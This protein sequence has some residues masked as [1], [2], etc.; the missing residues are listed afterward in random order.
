MPTLLHVI[1]AGRGDAMIIQDDA[2]G[3]GQM[4]LLDGGP[5]WY[6]AVPAKGAA[7]APYYRY[8]AAVLKQVSRELG[9]PAGSIRPDAIILSHTHDDHY[10]GIVDLFRRYLAESYTT[11]PVDDETLIFNGP[12][13]TQPL[14]ANR[15][16][17]TEIAHLLNAYQ[18]QKV[19]TAPAST[20]FARFAFTTNEVFVRPAPTL[21]GK[22]WTI[23]VSP[24]NI[25]SV[26][27]YHTASR[28]V[29]T[30]DGVGFKIEPFVGTQSG[31]LPSPIL[32]LF[33]V[34]HHGS[35]RN[36]Q[37][38]SLVAT[39]PSLVW[40]AYGLYVLLAW[41]SLSADQ[42]PPLAYNEPALKGAL[43]ALRQI[44]KRE[45][46]DPADFRDDLQTQF[47]AIL[48][49]IREGSVT[50]FGAATP[51]EVRSVWSQLD[52]RLTALSS[53]VVTRGKAK[54]T[55][56]KSPFAKLDEDILKEWVTSFLEGKELK[57]LYLARVANRQIRSF[58][59]RVRASA[60][61]ISANGAHR[62]PAAETLAA[63]AQVADEDHRDVT[64][65]VT[66]GR[67]VD[68]EA[69]NSLCPGWATR[70]TIRYLA[71]GARI[72]LDPAQANPDVRNV[73]DPLTS[74]TPQTTLTDLRKGLERYGGVRIPDQTVADVPYSLQ[75]ATGT[76]NA[77]LT[78][79]AGGTLSLAPARVDLL[80]QEGWPLLGLTGVNKLQLTLMSDMSRAAYVELFKIAGSA[81]YNIKCAGGWVSTDASAS[82]LAALRTDAAVAQFQM[83]RESIPVPV[84]G[85]LFAGGETLRDYC[86]AAG[87]STETPISCNS[88]I[89]IMVGPEA[90]AALLAQIH[91]DVALRVLGWNAD[92]DKSQVS[93]TR[94]G[95]AVVVSA[96]TIVIDPGTP[97]A[98]QNNG[99]AATI[100]AV[101]LTL[102][103][104]DT[105]S[106][107][108]DITTTDG[109][110]LNDS[111]VVTSP[112]RT[113]ALDAFLTALGVTASDLPGLTVASLLRWL[114]NG[115]PV[116]AKL[117]LGAP[118]F[119]QQAQLESWT[120]DHSSAWIESVST[121]MGTAVVRSASIPL[122]LSTTG[123]TAQIA[124]IALSLSTVVLRVEDGDTESPDIRLE[125]S[126]SGGGLQITMTITL[127]DEEPE[128][129]LSLPGSTTLAQAIGFLPG[130]PD[131]TGLTAPFSGGILSSL[132]LSSPS[133][134]LTQ[135][136][137]GVDAWLLSSISFVVQLTGWKTFLPEGCP[138][139]ASGSSFIC[140]Y[141]PV[142]ADHR[143]VGADVQ[144]TFPIQGT[145]GKKVDL[146]FSAWPVPD[147]ESDAYA[148]GISLE[149]DPDLPCTVTEIFGALGL[150]SLADVA[151]GAVPLLQSVFDG[152]SVVTLSATLIVPETGPAAWGDFALE[153]GLAESW[154]LLED[155]FTL[156][157]ASVNLVR[158][159][160]E[161][162]GSVA[163]SMFLGGEYRVDARYDLPTT[164]QPGCFR[165]V[166]GD[167]GLT[168]AALGGLFG[169]GD[170]SGVPVI[171][172]LLSIQLTDAQLDVAYDGESA[173][174][175]ITQATVQLYADEQVVGV[176]GL[177]ALAVRISHL[178]GSSD[179]TSAGM[180]GF[181]IEAEW[182]TDKIA[183]LAYDPVTRRVTAEIRLINAQTIG[184]LL[185]Q[186]L[187]SSVVNTLLPLI[188]DLAV[189]HGSLELDTTDLSIASLRV[190][191]AADASLQA[192]GARVTALAVEYQAARAATGDSPA[193][194]QRYVLTGTLHG[195]G[196]DAS[197]AL[198][199][200]SH[201]GQ[202]TIAATLQ[203]EPAP[204]PGI[205]LTGLVALFGLAAP[206]VNGPEG[207]PDSFDLRINRVAAK[208]TQLQSGLGLSAFSLDIESVGTLNL[209]ESPQ[210]DLTGVKVH[211]DYDAAQENPV[212]TGFFEGSLNIADAIGVTVRWQ[213]GKEG[214]EFHGVAAAASGDT[215]PQ[216]SALLNQYQLS[217]QFVLPADLNPPA[218]I[219]LQQLEVHAKPGDYVDIAGWA[220][221]TDWTVPGLGLSLAFAGLGGRVRIEYGKGQ[222]T[223]ATYRAWLIGALSL[224]GYAAAR[225]SFELGTAHRIISAAVTGTDASSVAVTTLLDALGAGEQG[226]PT[227]SGLTPDG[228]ESIGAGV[229]AYLYIDLTDRLLALYGSLTE[230]G[231]ALLMCRTIQPGQS[232]QRRTLFAFNLGANFTFAQLWSVLAPIDDVFALIRANALVLDYGGATGADLTADVQAVSAYAAAQGI[233]FVAP[234]A[235]LTLDNGA[236]LPQGM[237]FAADIDM[238]ATGQSLSG[239]LSK[240]AATPAAAPSLQL[241]AAFNH[242]STLSN[243]IFTATVHQLVLVGGSLTLDG[244]ISYQHL[245]GQAA[246]LSINGTLA[247]VFPGGTS[248]TFTGALAVSEQT[249]GFA[250]IGPDQP[251]SLP[252]PLGMFG[253][254]ITSPALSVLYTFA[255]GAG[256]VGSAIHIGGTVSLQ[257]LGAS[258]TAAIDFVD[259][260]PRLA[261]VLLAENV[262]ILDLFADIIAG[263][264]SSGSWPGG[265]EPIVLQSG[266]LYY[267]EPADGQE[268]TVNGVSYQAGYHVKAN[269]SIFGEPFMIDVAIDSQRRGV[270]V[271]G[272]YPGKIDLYF[273]KLTPYTFV[274]PDTKQPVTTDGPAVSI[275]T[276]DPGATVYEVDTGVEVFGT[277]LV[278]ASFKYQPNTQNPALSS[279]SGQFQ[280]PGSLCGIDQPTIGFTY[281]SRQGLRISQWPALAD[282]E[283]ALQWLQ[284]IESAA[285]SADPCGALAGLASQAVGGA[286]TTRIDS[287]FEQ[288]G[289]DAPITSGG[290]TFALKGNYII[291]IAGQDL[292]PLP[293]P[294]IELTIPIPSDFSVTGMLDW[295]KGAVIQNAGQIAKGLLKDPKAATIFF[296]RIGVNALR[297]EVIGA[298][299]CRGIKPP[300]VVSRATD[301]ANEGAEES[302]SEAEEA[303]SAEE[304]ADAAAT[305][306]DLV[307]ATVTAEGALDVILGYLAWL[308]GLISWLIPGFDALFSRASGDRDRA[309]AALDA[310]NARVQS[311]LWMPPTPTPTC[312]FVAAD[313]VTVSWSN[314]QPRMQDGSA[315][316]YQG[317]AGLRYRVQWADSA[318]FSNPI[319][320]QETHDQSTTLT[321][322]N[323]SIARTHALHARVCSIY[324]D[325]Q[326]K[327]WVWAQWVVAETVS[328]AVVLP[329]PASATVV[330]DSVHDCVVVTVATVPSAVDYAVDL[331][332][333]AHGN[334]VVQSQTVS[335]V[336]GAASAT[337]SFAVVGLP[338]LPT[339]A[340]LLARVVAKGDQV[341]DLDAPPVSSPLA[342]P[343]SIMAAPSGLAATSS[344]DALNV[345]WA[346]AVSGQSFA[347]VVL[348]TT[349][350]LLAQQPTVTFNAAGCVLAGLA[351]GMNGQVRVRVT[352]ASPTVVGLWSALLPVGLLPSVSGLQST[353]S[354]SGDVVTATWSNA[355]GATGFDVQLSTHDHPATPVYAGSCTGT[356]LSLPKGVVQPGVSYSLQVRATAPGG[357]GPWS[358]IDVCIVLLPAVAGL[359]TL[360]SS[361]DGVLTATWSKVTGAASFDVQLFTRADP[362]TAVYAGSCKAQ[363]L[364]PQTF[365]LP[366]GTVQ[367]GVPY[368]L[369]VRAT[370]AQRVGPWA[371]V[372]VL[373]V[374]L[375][376]PTG[377]ALSFD[378]SNSFEPFI[379]SWQPIEPP[380]P[381]S[382]SAIRYVAALCRNLPSL[383][384]V[385]MTPPVYDSPQPMKRTDGN[386]LLSDSSYVARVRAQS[387]GAVGPWSDASVPVVPKTILPP[388]N[389]T[390]SIQAGPAFYVTWEPTV[391]PYPGN[392]VD[393]Q[394]LLMLADVTSPVVQDRAGVA[395]GAPTSRW[396]GGRWSDWVNGGP[397]AGDWYT[398][399]I[400]AIVAG[401]SSAWATSNIVWISD[402]VT[403]NDPVYS[404]NRIQVS[405]SKSVTPQ[406]GYEVALWKPDVQDPILS[407]SVPCVGDAAPTNATI[408]VTGLDKSVQ[409][410]VGVRVVFRDQKGDWSNTFTIAAID[411]PA[412]FAVDTSKTLWVTSWAA[413]A[414]ASSYVVEVVDA[415]AQIL[416]SSQT[417]S[418][419]AEID[420]WAIG[421]ARSGTA[422]VRALVGSTSSLRSKGV[423]VATAPL[424]T[425]TSACLG[426]TPGTG[427]SA[428]NTHPAAAGLFTTMML[429]LTQKDV[430]TSFFP[431]LIDMGLGTPSRTGW[432][433]V[434]EQSWGPIAVLAQ[435]VLRL[436]TLGILS[437]QQACG[438]FQSTS[439]APVPPPA[440]DED[441]DTMTCLCLGTVPGGSCGNGALEDVFGAVH[442]LLAS[443]V[444]NTRF[445][446]LQA[447]PRTGWVVAREK[448][449]F[450]LAVLIQLVTRLRLK[451]TL[452]DPNVPFDI[453]NSTAHS[454]VR[455]GAGGP[456]TCIYVG[457]PFGSVDSGAAT[458]FGDLVLSVAADQVASTY[459]QA[460]GWLAVD[461][462][463]WTS[464]VALLQLVKILASQGVLSGSEPYDIFNLAAPVKVWD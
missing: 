218:Q 257:R 437:G 358:N 412:S 278:D 68:L 71:R 231:T 318:D 256:S 378:D 460:N 137:A 443:D 102:A 386:W 295:I 441:A 186:L 188:Q 14:L 390:L 387:Q 327:T 154:T 158:N 237:W 415:E 15:Q 191:L 76:G 224:P 198:D 36:S 11:D 66:N 380:A 422:Y 73:T 169:T 111:A 168:L 408:D 342:N 379:V 60:F 61:V 352:S 281:S 81:N 24:D 177:S 85:A 75:C 211:V 47:K 49:A 74:T 173:V 86:A 92:F 307:A 150:S 204:S 355:P 32:P 315:F 165:L 145:P 419:R 430:D 22:T 364:D 399:R 194:D 183:T 142:D 453:F 164:A 240:L 227:W 80:V 38:A 334:A 266:L 114:G 54:T 90:S 381:L 375:L 219:P 43:V 360:Y 98:F 157:S 348:D 292:V 130:T 37:R 324:T 109:T 29:F 28:M 162:S 243:T 439:A 51:S 282:L 368:S 30:G 16:G 322:T 274:D 309:Q 116:G 210:I 127:S 301:L 84:L 330:Y 421:A 376:A 203:S 25:E 214:Y 361:G 197:I 212:P 135:P 23:D 450:P 235:G 343:L 435:L 44:L 124:G 176:L 155:K 431:E 31:A 46:I 279:Y 144:L 200:V 19:G 332:D 153:L 57:E 434:P 423:P 220:S 222:N 93:F 248:A 351:A 33:K 4:Y 425:Y 187:G 99:V 331:L 267:C 353:Y 367:A 107:T 293:L 272:T 427:C 205:T 59:R 429:Y 70:T 391:P 50:P 223:P 336:A 395:Y 175:R 251:A 77:Y 134:T 199:C 405:W 189:Q 291:T 373:P 359:T 354:P 13:I 17:Q 132:S 139:P 253:V 326:S 160:G 190:A 344:G 310:A 3:S 9:R 97:L 161:W 372:N 407:Q 62:H 143:Q 228:M 338:A 119:L 260:V 449:Y 389:V 179:G 123:L 166:S 288:T 406:A 236:E 250:L 181:W 284:L 277:A 308:A 362:A 89:G 18:F 118:S 216:Y 297:R 329:S 221:A 1:Y 447:T 8:L 414:G 264:S 325:Q 314:N 58:F 369:Q 285:S 444:V 172:P 397:K 323:A 82:Y 146:W 440:Q 167:A 110:T 461:Q 120:I 208:L 433:A 312:Q 234:F 151:S 7:P 78:I 104:N 436:T 289:G 226:A 225:A 170:L 424:G 238:G 463:P 410:R 270:K 129:E 141:N 296:A 345:V 34:P 87:I 299:I 233:S 88:L 241:Q 438:V 95:S 21:L 273:A 426:P 280:Y 246:S 328:H 232:D 115:G 108:V 94:D 63:I 39:V 349:G 392:Q 401:L 53:L 65:F 79:G 451:G 209:L 131:L 184:A 462:Q 259:S 365:A 459:T 337:A 452:A 404:G 2:G 202:S 388:S 428:S 262:S 300:N 178:F 41:E 148:Y 196:F 411:A 261:T 356:T 159:H 180:T 357:V 371:S 27:A 374:N 122:V 320:T 298:L 303:S 152:L 67:C 269:L 55:A 140:V 339:G 206:V 347:I 305:M 402:A 276:L 454:R 100:D 242:G 35:L 193:V 393:Y 69:L 394:L 317:Y 103:W 215:P 286:I 136:V 377:V 91:L 45:K 182:G 311:A 174:P 245:E 455:Q 64:I 185:G 230:L 313:T 366:A 147:D 156:R 464:L 201:E 302:A 195:N 252:Q 254:V 56:K 229:A 346:H 239:N 398:V 52:K 244:L 113:T 403:L 287:H 457:S 255:D 26:L 275:S 448:P 370:A 121:P 217:Q 445:L 263:T 383:D 413:L 106:L 341:R 138:T 316:N 171:G 400:Q 416:A 20:V 247:I 417:S 418:L 333:V 83:A 133:C 335:A 306:T 6:V 192:A 382:S 126:A 409:Y 321:L 12:F 213:Q 249:A 117:L 125:M 432:V 350:H 304:A 42:L 40:Q 112:V 294:D 442:S 149:A 207:A 101:S 446:P 48:K 396:L 363:S 72:V 265:Y 458:R 340:A 96:A 385:G 10:G 5:L 384:I 258:L 268:V 456:S 128:L 283:G 290:L 163:G 105:L 319:L 420:S 271:S